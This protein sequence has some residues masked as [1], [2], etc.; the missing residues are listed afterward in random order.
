MK[1]KSN[2]NCS[3]YKV[4]KFISDPDRREQGR[5]K[6]TTLDFMT[7]AFD[8]FKDW[9]EESCG[10]WLWRRVQESS[11]IFQVSLASDSGIANPYLWEIKQR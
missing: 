10:K 9:L 5:K 3:D 2:L 7:V 4:V 8:I 11:L 6:I 1:F